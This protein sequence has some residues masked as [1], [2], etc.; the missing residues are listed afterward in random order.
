MNSRF[1]L[2]K[3]RWSGG[4][5][6]WDEKESLEEFIA[7]A[8]AAL[9]VSK[10]KE[11][12]VTI[13]P[14]KNLLV[15]MPSWNKLIPQM[16]EKQAVHMAYQPIVNLRTRQPIGY[17]ALARPIG[18]EASEGIEG[19]FTIASKIGKAPDLDWLCR[20]LAIE[21]IKLPKERLLFINVSANSLFESPHE[22]ELMENLLEKR[23]MKPWEIVLEL[24]EKE[25]YR[26]TSRITEVLS[27][28]R[29]KGFSLALDDVGEGM[30]SGEFLSIF[31]AD[32]IKL[33]KSVI[34]KSFVLGERTVFDG[35]VSWAQENG[36]VVIAKGVETQQQLESLT[37]MG[38][39]IG[40]GFL[41][42]S[43]Q[44]QNLTGLTQDE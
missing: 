34:P 40:Q 14:P 42:G 28:Y 12:I 25:L 22:I 15:K 13:A 39:E 18:M 17:E 41:L 29:K 43:P 44:F 27:L 20:R 21:E 31:N 11:S 36:A 23:G 3:Q 26:D 19:L 5:A 1:T 2:T 37:G 9:Y 4:I 8:D 10:N 16:L 38:I 32:Y 35:L 30:L 33:A 6:C 24:N 7:R